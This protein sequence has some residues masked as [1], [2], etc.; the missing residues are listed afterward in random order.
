M[1]QF[2]KQLGQTEEAKI[3]FSNARRAALGKLGE[4]Q[5]QLREVVRLHPADTQAQINLGNLLT[6]LGE[7]EEAKACFSNALRLE[8]DAVETG[9]DAARKNATVFHF[10]DRPCFRTQPKIPKACS[11]HR[12]HA[13]RL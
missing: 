2:K 3:C 12:R 11:R 9:D 8:P 5:T 13:D 6:E 7:I 10:E 1:P 4:A